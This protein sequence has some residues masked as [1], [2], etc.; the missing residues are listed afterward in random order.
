LVKRLGFL[1]RKEP[2]KYRL[3]FETGSFFFSLIPF[4]SPFFRGVEKGLNPDSTQLESQISKI[5]PLSFQRLCFLS[6]DTSRFVIGRRRILVI[7][8]S[9]F[10]GK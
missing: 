2:S 7:L 1:G 6:P 9:K 4:F 3:V 10:K 5:Y 8:S